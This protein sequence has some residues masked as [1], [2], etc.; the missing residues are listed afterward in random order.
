[1]T[2]KRPPALL[3][4]ALS[5][6][7]VFA[8]EVGVVIV[9]VWLVGR[10]AT[11]HLSADAVEGVIIALFMAATAINEIMLGRRIAKLEKAQQVGAAH[12]AACD[13]LAS[14]RVA[15]FTDEQAQALLREGMTAAMRER[16]GWQP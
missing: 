13:A 16:G 14:F 6:A 15:G 10:Y 2:S 4:R 5:V 12:A 8:L 11:G 3:S 9:A 1:M 7:V